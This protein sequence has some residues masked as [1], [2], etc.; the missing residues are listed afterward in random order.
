M[1]SK[2][3]NWFEIKLE[4][5]IA[6]LNGILTLMSIPPPKDVLPS[7]PPTYLEFKGNVH[8]SIVFKTFT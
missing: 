7:P 5:V 1:E 6:L 2:N 3:G 8:F 4:T